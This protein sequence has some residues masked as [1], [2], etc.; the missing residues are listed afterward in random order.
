MEATTPQLTIALSPDAIDAIADKLAERLAQTPLAPA[1]SA[2][3]TK[4]LW[5]EVEA[6]TA[7]SISPLTLKK[8]RE[9]RYVQSHTTTRP[10]LYSW[11][12]IE[13][14]AEWMAGRQPESNN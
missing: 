8:W 3:P 4:L 14:I 11:P 6:A 7:L 12:Q 9:R 10:V 1:G 13:S 5:T 2:Q